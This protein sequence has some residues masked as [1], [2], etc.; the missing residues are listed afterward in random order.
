[1]RARHLR[2]IACAACLIAAATAAAQRPDDARVRTFAALPNWTGIWIVADGIMND[3]GV[4]GRPP[5]G[6]AEYA[7]LVL[8]NGVPYTKEA[9]ARVAASRRRATG[10][11]KE[12]GFP[13]PFVMESPWVFELLV[14]PEET[15]LIAGG[16][17]IRHIYT[18]GRGH[19]KPEDVWPTPWGD[20][21]GR[22]DA[23]TLV[24]DTIAV[25]PGRFPPSLSEHA[26]FT[27]RL[28][29]LDADHMQDRM[30][31]DDPESLT[32]PWT[33]TLRYE[34][35]K[36]LDR[37]VHGDCRENDRNPIVDGKVTIAPAH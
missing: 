25:Q 16:R 35:V 23:E 8:Q 15:A 13:F 27:E 9:A 6:D 34:R 10:T 17:E 31:I 19:P 20:S 3:L 28:R 11:E 30:T 21:V 5:G 33:I 32:R 12:C 22:W 2:P 36:T 24:V 18:D 37:I 14:T 1:M 7:K 4:S 26:H 29:R